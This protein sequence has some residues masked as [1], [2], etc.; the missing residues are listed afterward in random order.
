MLHTWHFFIDE[1]AAKRKHKQA[2]I[3]VQRAW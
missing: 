3:F 1:T 2:G